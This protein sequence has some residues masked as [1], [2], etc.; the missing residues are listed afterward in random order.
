MWKTGTIMAN[1]LSLHKAMVG[2]GQNMVIWFKYSIWILL[3]KGGKDK[4]SLKTYNVKKYL[5]LYKMYL[6]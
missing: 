2:P 4:K 6:C 5:G 3:K 1:F